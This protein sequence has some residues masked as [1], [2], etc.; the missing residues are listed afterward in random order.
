MTATVAEP[1]AVQ[2]VKAAVRCKAPP[3]D[4]VADWAAHHESPAA[5]AAAAGMWQPPLPLLHAQP[6]MQPAMTPP[7]RVKAPWQPP[8]KA[9]PANSAIAA[10]AWTMQAME[11]SAP[12]ATAAS[13]AAAVAE[14]LHPMINMW[15]ASQI[16]RPF[17]QE[18]LSMSEFLTRLH[19]RLLEHHTAMIVS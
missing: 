13:A 4:V 12:S 6:A 2:V 9:P 18:M 8:V 7:I 17:K 10:A 15:C 19:D 1:P 16:G 14:R 11:T 3:P 5:V